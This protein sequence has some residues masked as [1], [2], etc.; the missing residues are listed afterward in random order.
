MRIIIIGEIIEKRLPKKSNYGY[1]I[2]SMIMNNLDKELVNEFHKKNKKY[3]YLSFSNV[4]IKENNGHFYVVGKNDIVKSLIEHLVAN[5][6]IRLGDM[7]IKITKIMPIDELKEKDKYLFRTNLIVNISKNQN[8]VLSN[9]F[10]YIEKRLKE[11]AI[12]KAKKCGI[13]KSNLDFEI[14]NP[15]HKIN[16]YKDGHINSWKCFLKVTG[17]YELVNFLYTT[18]GVGENTATGHGLLWEVN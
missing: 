4:Y 1:E 9:E 11:I 12:N 8:C 18:S 2:Y 14:I 17:D 3:R 15:I 13:D 5:M 6:V 16:K 7:I 10:D